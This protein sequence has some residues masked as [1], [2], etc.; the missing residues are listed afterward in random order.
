MIDP[1]VIQIYTYYESAYGCWY[2]DIFSLT[3]L[4]GDQNATG[5]LIYIYLRRVVLLDTDTA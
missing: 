4:I 5:S 3:I 1:L 2:L